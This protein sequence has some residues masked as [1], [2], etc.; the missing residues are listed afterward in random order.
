MPLIDRFNGI[1]IHVY[2]GEHRP[3]HIH[4]VYNDHEALIVI[5][6]RQI[7]AG[8]LPKKPLKL[9]FNW[10]AEHSEWALAI[11]YELNPDLK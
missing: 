2:N 9:V 10:L 6:T 7:Y 5:E 4:A 3:P 11:F 1:K 8:Y